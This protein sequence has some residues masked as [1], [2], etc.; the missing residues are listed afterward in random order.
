MP[1]AWGAPAVTKECL[2]WRWRGGRRD[3]DGEGQ[4]RP[5]GSRCGAGRGS[6]GAV[7]LAMQSGALC[8][9]SPAHAVGPRSVLSLHAPT[10][11]MEPLKG[12][13]SVDPT[14]R[15]LSKLWVLARKESWL[16]SGGTVP[17]TGVRSAFALSAP[18]LT[19]PVLL[20]VAT[21]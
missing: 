3:G 9:R 11:A 8:A 20:V 12:E 5:R 6:N 2:T 17:V 4:A 7:D 10:P 19:P 21:V 1:G 18:L 13:R 16:Q 15:W 14:Q